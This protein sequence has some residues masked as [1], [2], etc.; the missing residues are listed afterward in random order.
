[1]GLTLARRM[2]GGGDARYQKRHKASLRL[3]KLPCGWW[4]DCGSKGSEEEFLNVRVGFALGIQSHRD[5][6]NSCVLSRGTRPHEI[7]AP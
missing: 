3:D 7:R 1:V 2:G 5:S 4:E 6:K